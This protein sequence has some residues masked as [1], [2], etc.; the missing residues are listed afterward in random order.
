MTS[1]MKQIEVNRATV[2]HLTPE[3]KL[4]IENYVKKKE[5]N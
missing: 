4:E 5:K 1:T 3:Q 2:E